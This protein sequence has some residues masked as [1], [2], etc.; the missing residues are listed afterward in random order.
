[1]ESTY[2]DRLYQVAARV[3]RRYASGHNPHSRDV[4]LLNRHAL[5]FQSGMNPA[6]LAGV[7][8]WR[9]QN[10]TGALDSAA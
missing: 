7:T 5:S 9:I 10:A 6:E 2:V 8:I 1:M 4:Q 3:L